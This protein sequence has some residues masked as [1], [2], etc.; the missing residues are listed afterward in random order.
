MSEYRSADLQNCRQK[1]IEF[2][3]LFNRWTPAAEMA[4]NELQQAFQ[5]NVWHFLTSESKFERI[6]RFLSELLCTRNSSGRVFNHHFLSS[7]SLLCGH[8]RPHCSLS[9]LAALKQNRRRN[10]CRSSGFSTFSTRGPWMARP[11]HNRGGGHQLQSD[12]W[13]RLAATVWKRA[14]SA[15]KQ[16]VH[17]KRGGGGETFFSDKTHVWVQ[18]ERFHMRPRPSWGCLKGWKMQTLLQN[19]G[20][21]ECDC[22]YARWLFYQWAKMQWSQKLFV[23]G[24]QAILL[25]RLKHW[26]PPIWCC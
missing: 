19:N 8:K 20:P 13:Q 11:R 3:Q 4:A 25:H 14:D 2:F 5:L 10:A 26:P 23:L 18:L 16:V 7:M 9:P 17:Y 21:P 1:H 6:S 24:V 22:M 15:Q 12:V